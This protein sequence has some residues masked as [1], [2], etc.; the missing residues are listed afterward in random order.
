MVQKNHRKNQGEEI[1]MFLKI[2]NERPHVSQLSGAAL[3]PYGHIQWH[4]QF[5]HVL[6]KGSYPK[7][8]LEEKNILL[9]TV[10]EHNSQDSNV[11]FLF[12]RQKLTA[13]YY[14]E[15]YGAKF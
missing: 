15:F 8:R 2:W 1:R 14:Q 6:P 5:L 3:L 10:A 11:D 13:E 4:W 12:I 7:W 9:G